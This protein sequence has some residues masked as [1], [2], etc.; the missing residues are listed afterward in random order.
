M[1]QFKTIIFN[2]IRCGVVVNIAVFQ[3]EV[4]QIRGISRDWA[5]QPGV[6]FPVPEIS[7]PNVIF[8]FTPD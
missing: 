7:F 1:E 5:R 2:N 8:L 6:R 4:P 3:H